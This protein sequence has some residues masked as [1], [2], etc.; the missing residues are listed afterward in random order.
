MT[1]SEDWQ[2]SASIEMLKKRAALLAQI[3]EFFAQRNVL[4]VETPALSFASVTDV[5]LR[6]FSSQFNDPYSVEPKTLYLQTSPEFA[7]KRLLCAGSGCIYQICKAFRNEE[8]G[9]FHNPEFTMLEWYRV[10]FDHLDLIQEIDA[11]LQ[12]TL[13][14]KPLE[15]ITYQQAFIEHCDIDPL[16]CTHAELQARASDLGFS[17]IADNESDSDVLLQ[18]LCCQVVEKQIGLERPVALTNF[19]APQA[20]LARLSQSDSRVASRFEIYYKGVELANGYHELTQATEQVR[21]FK[22]DNA[23][24]KLLKLPQIDIDQRLI[25]A[26][27][28]G[29]PDC[30]GVALGVDRLCMLA[31]DVQHIEKI[32]AFPVNIA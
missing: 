6:A 2:P 3:R 31:M 15:I 14:S 12:M 30:A 25:Q 26:L 23:Q 28:N 9:R 22:R 1:N 11:L 29:L 24:R 8:S 21:R 17:N 27:E 5:H 32:T 19:P 7:M 10:G 18:L 4:E 16:A 13:G 20:A